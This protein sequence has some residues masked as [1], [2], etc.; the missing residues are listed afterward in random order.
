MHIIG[1]T[2]KFAYNQE[3]IPHTCPCSRDGRSDIT[4]V[5]PYPMKIA[6]PDGSGNMMCLCVSLSV[7]VCVCMCVVCVCVHVSV[8]VGVNAHAY[9]V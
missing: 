4:C 3:R 7:C 1:G 2:K 9:V 8:K 5:P 6:P